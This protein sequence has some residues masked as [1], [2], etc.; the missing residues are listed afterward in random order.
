[1]NSK[2]PILQQHPPT[3]PQIKINLE[4]LDRVK[5]ESCEGEYFDLVWVIHK[6]PA[7][8]S[9]T[10]KEALFPVTFFRCRDC[11]KVTKIIHNK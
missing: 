6:V 1:M 4:D 2:K 9:Q 11:L 7:M 3:A 8:L 5:C 10:G